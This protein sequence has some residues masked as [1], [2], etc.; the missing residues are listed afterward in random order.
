MVTAN[1]TPSAPTIS[2]G[3]ATTFCQGGSV[4]L[5]SSASS[6]NLWST[7]ATTQNIT[8]S[9][10]GSYTVHYTD[11]NGC[12]SS[13]SAATVVTVNATPSAPTIS[14]SSATTFCQ[15]GSVVL[16]S[17]ASSNNL[18]STSATTQ[19]ITVSTLGNYTV[20]YTDANGCTSPN[21]AATVVI[22]ST[23]ATANAGSNQMI[24]YNSAATLNGSIGGSASSATWST[25]GD[26]VFN[27]ANSL[28]AIYTPG[29]LDKTNG[30]VVLTLVT[31]DPVGSCDAE[32]S[33][34]T[35][36]IRPELIVTAMPGTIP[37]NG[38]TT[39]VAVSAT[40]GSGIYNPNDIGTFANVYAGTHTYTVTD[41]AGC[42][43]STTITITEPAAIVVT[44]AAGTID[45][46]RG[47]TF[48][49]V[50]ATGGSGNYVSGTG[51]FTHIKAGTYTYTVTDDN[52]CSGSTTITVADGTAD[53]PPRPGGISGQ[54]TNLCAGGI[55]TYTI[56]PVPNATSYI[57]TYP[58]GFTEISNTGT[59]ITLSIPQGLIYDSISVQG[60]NDCG[61]SHSKKLKLHGSPNSAVISGATVVQAQ[62][63]GVVYTVTNVQAG[64]T[65]IWTTEYNSIE[66]LSGQGTPSITVKFGNR[67]GF[68]RVQTTNACGSSGKTDY[69]VTVVFNFAKSG[70][71]VDGQMASQQKDVF[72]VFPNP[73]Q[74]EAKV[75]FTA[76][77]EDKYVLELSD[78]AGKVLLR[79]E[80]NAATGINQVDLD[81]HNYANGLY[82]INVICND[83][84]KTIKLIKGK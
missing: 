51:K 34:M 22:V 40:G 28:N 29:P 70:G 10:S 6:N 56:A 9:T 62:Q 71:S 74:H 64:E 45:C 1:A 5:T 79:K 18:W 16:T 75:I 78:M 53:R 19:S 60:K 58:P 77:K 2:A 36:T 61:T 21:S 81:V 73:A 42:S 39:S 65:C 72:T 25:R 26:G 82:F 3:S 37:C 47:K 41:N 23:A 8:V 27:N 17:S 15:G 52:G 49:Q 12:T 31:D 13:N 55:Y 33:T 54:S 83:E 76:I 69:P 67:S 7:N 38:G 24:C 32:T 63:S 84:R 59:G 68:I 20:Q 4:V 48:V 50:S 66:I 44:A 46:K 80:G 35:L 14:A 43:G 30:S 11:A 57:W